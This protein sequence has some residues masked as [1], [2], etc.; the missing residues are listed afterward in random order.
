MQSGNF[1]KTAYAY[2]IIC[3]ISII[4][5]IIQIIKNISSKKMLNVS[6]FKNTCNN[7]AHLKTII[8][9]LN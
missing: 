7:L 1:I 4:T 8:K 6:F 5:K 2:S 9:I 3:K